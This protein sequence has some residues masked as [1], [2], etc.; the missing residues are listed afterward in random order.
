MKANQL[1]SNDAAKQT[2]VMVSSNTVEALGLPKVWE[3][4]S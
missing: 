4:L 2:K 1:Q 3:A